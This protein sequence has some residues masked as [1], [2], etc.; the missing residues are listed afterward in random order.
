MSSDTHTQNALLNHGK[1][2]MC[3]TPSP[4]RVDTARRGE[5]HPRSLEVP[6]QF[7][8]RGFIAGVMLP[9][10]SQRTP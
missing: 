2:A 4:S 3:G 6:S 10:A 8:S 9:G 7:K 1:L 5:S